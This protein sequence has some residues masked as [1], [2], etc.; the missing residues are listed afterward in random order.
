VVFVVPLTAS[1]QVHQV[2]I[3][4]EGAVVARTPFAV[5]AAGADESGQQ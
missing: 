1:V 2:M 5:T 3:S 4:L